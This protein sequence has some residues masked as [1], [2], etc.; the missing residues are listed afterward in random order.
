MKNLKKVILRKSF[1]YFR[2]C[3]HQPVCHAKYQV[4]TCYFN[5]SQSVF[6][7]I[8]LLS[9]VLKQA[10]THARNTHAAPWSYM[11]HAVT[12][13]KGL[14]RNTILT[15]GGGR[16]SMRTWVQI[17]STHIKKIKVRHGLEC[18]QPNAVGV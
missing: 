2:S 16:T 14:K 11:M 5:L 18:L 10:Q 3:L 6:G 13:V 8:P 17:S 9:G 15:G 1:K 12:G 7:T 4:F